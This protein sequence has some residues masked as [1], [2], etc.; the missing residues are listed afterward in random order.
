M[1][2]K[3]WLPGFRGSGSFYEPA[4]DKACKPAAE[5]SCQSAGYDTG[6]DVS[7]IMLADKYPADAYHAGPEEYP[8]TVAAV[9]L[10]VVVSKPHA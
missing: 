7:E 9:F 5:E 4:D 8:G 10:T 6:D 1:S 3:A 2:Y